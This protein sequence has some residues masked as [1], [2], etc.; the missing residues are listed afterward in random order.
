MTKRLCKKMKCS[1]Y[2]RHK[3]LMIAPSVLKKNKIRFARVLSLL[4][5]Q[6]SIFHNYSIYYSKLWIIVFIKHLTTKSTSVSRFIANLSFTIVKYIQALCMI[7]CTY[8]YISTYIAVSDT[9]L[10]ALSVHN[11]GPWETHFRIATNC[12]TV[13]HRT[14]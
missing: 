13:P 4:Y 1:F 6:F 3:R 14:V 8:T 11:F 5:V 10:C 7:L 2:L 12:L 9:P